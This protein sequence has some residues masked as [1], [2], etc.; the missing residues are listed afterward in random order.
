MLA[1]IRRRTMDED[2]DTERPSTTTPLFD[3]K[4]V[5]SGV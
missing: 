3:A 4:S 1:K 5:A 2:R